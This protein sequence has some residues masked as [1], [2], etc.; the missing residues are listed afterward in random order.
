MRFTRT[1]TTA[2]A[3]LAI[4]LSSFAAAPAAQATAPAHHT[5]HGSSLVVKGSRPTIT[6]TPSTTTLTYQWYRHDR[7]VAG[8][9]AAT[10]TLTA[11]DVGRRIRVVV[12]GSADGYRSTSRVSASTA[13]V[14]AP[15]LTT[16]KPLVSGTAQV[17][18]VLTAD[19]GTW[20]PAG[21]T[22]SYQWFRSGKKI[23]NA[24]AS[25]YTLVGADFRRTLTVKVTG[26]LAGYATA[27]RVSART[28]KVTAGTLTLTPVPTISGTAAVGQKLAATAGIWGPG[29]V[30]LTYQWFRSG[31]K[32]RH[33]N[34]ATYRVRAAD[35]GTTLTVAVTGWKYGYLPVTRV[36]AGTVIGA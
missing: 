7:K 16:T 15:P 17:G 24:T 22:L 6:G 33:A 25:T 14:I 21:V 1:I 12:T 10:Y 20:G 9:T 11:S 3:A 27:S 31:V 29:K 8:S 2:F 4:G 18:S 34:H 26:R 23:R 32:I 19:P 13:K 35:A 28:A 5:S 36:S 30:V